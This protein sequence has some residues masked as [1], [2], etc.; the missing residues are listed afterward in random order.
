MEPTYTGSE[1]IDRDGRHYSAE[2]TIRFRPER[3]ATGVGFSSEAQRYL[4]ATFGADHAERGDDVWRSVVKAVQ[5]AE[6]RLAKRPEINANT[7]RAEVMSVR[8]SEGASREDT[9]YLLAGAS[10]AA[11]ERFFAALDDGRVHLQPWDIGQHFEYRPSTGFDEEHISR[12]RCFLEYVA[13]KRPGFLFG[14]AVSQAMSIEEAIRERTLTACG[15]SAF[16]SAVCGYLWGCRPEADALVARAHELL[17]L[18]DATDE[19]SA[20]DY[21]SGWGLGQRYT[22]LAYVHWLRTGE[23]HDAAL[24]EAR[25]RLLAYYRRT[26]HFDRRTANLAAPALLFLGA[27][28]VLITMAERLAAR[29]GR[30]AAR[31]GGLFGDAL[32]IAT[33]ADGA[34]RDRLRAKLRKRMPLHLFRWMHHGQYP[35]MAFM[36]HAVFPRPE[37]P[38][39]RLIERAWD[40]MPEIERRPGADFGWDIARKSPQ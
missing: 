3:G 15:E 21:A 31:P 30:G 26:K 7:F 36:L 39:S 29:P 23:S 35:D 11:A 40:F 38:P 10:R 17:T 6:W 33:A 14:F 32:R 2:V 4:N 37:G 25:A 20:G 27:D 1:E 5:A 19:K 13:E 34:E 8:V 22:A 28:S 18:A 9:A 16:S 24:A 12:R